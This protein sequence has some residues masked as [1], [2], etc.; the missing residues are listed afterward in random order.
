MIRERL[1]LYSLLNLA[2]DVFLLIFSFIL[3]YLLIWGHFKPNFQI[4]FL[5]ASVAL[6]LCWIITALV[7]K[8]Y[9]G[10]QYEFFGRSLPKHFLAII[11]HA[12]LLS[13]VV[14]LI[15]D[16]TISRIL[17]IYAYLLFVFLDVLF[18]LCLI[19]VFRYR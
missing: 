18:R 6:L 19:Y 7:L 12:L 15:K 8:L 2:G 16:F 10:E 9:G 17:F 11:F 5:K 1:R 14:F 4:Y 3:A 13:I